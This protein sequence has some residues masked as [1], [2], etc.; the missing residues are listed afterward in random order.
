MA[1]PYE[2]ARVFQGQDAILRP[3]MPV[4]DRI[5]L[6]VTLL[7]LGVAAALFADASQ[8]QLEALQQCADAKLR[9]EGYVT[10]AQLREVRGQQEERD[11]WRACEVRP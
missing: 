3:I 8:R 5:I 10:P 6:A 7:S 4:P 9:E 2:S 11:A 1:P